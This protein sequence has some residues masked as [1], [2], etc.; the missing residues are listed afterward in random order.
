MG[1]VTLN[2][3]NAKLDNLEKA[4]R[5][6]QVNFKFLLCMESA[7]SG[8]KFKLKSFRKGV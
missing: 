7:L 2:D 5:A 6:L 1:A 4:I 8:S 3:N